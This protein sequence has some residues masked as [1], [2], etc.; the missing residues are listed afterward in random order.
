M[1]VLPKPEPDFLLPPE[2][3]PEPDVELDLV[4]AVTLAVVGGFGA[5]DVD[6]V[7]NPAPEKFT[8]SDISSN[9]LFGNAPSKFTSFET[10]LKLLIC[11]AP[12]RAKEASNDKFDL[13]NA[14]SCATEPSKLKPDLLNAP[15]SLTEPSNIKLDFLKAPSLLTEPSKEIVASPSITV[16]VAN[17]A[18]CC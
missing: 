17:W 1:K 9:E 12:S 3:E 14:P 10:S 18:N 7:D 5:D 2:D 4:G 13:P 6:D 16:F 15:S 8:S 11:I